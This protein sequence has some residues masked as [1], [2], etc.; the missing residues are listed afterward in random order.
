M[1]ASLD[2]ALTNPEDTTVKVGTASVE[3]RLETDHLSSNTIAVRLILAP[4][5]NVQR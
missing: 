4:P 2:T 5:E 3:V 1:L